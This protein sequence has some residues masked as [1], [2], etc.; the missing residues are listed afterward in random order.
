MGDLFP[1]VIILFISGLVAGTM[2]TIAGGGGLITV[3]VLF[4]FPWSPVVAF[5]TNKFQSTFGSF[6]ATY[7]FW[8]AGT[9]GRGVFLGVLFTAAGA[10]SGAV[11]VNIVPALWL[12]KFIPFL[13]F[14]IALV[15]FFTKG[16]GA[17]PGRQRMPVPLFMAVFGLSIGFYDGFFGPGTGT[18]WAMGF[19][20]LLG[21]DLKEATAST[22]LMNFTSNFVSLLFFLWKGAVNFVPGLA[23][24]LGQFIGGWLGTR[25][26]LRK[27][28]KFI[29]PVLIFMALVLAA[30]LFWDN[31]LK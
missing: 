23:M 17:R 11:V 26:V 21:K 15:L 4:S 9:I 25:L 30:K 28:S 5:G 31:W 20:W 3:P 7:H 2:D 22:K 14:A 19:V 27:G 1:T 16:F 24:A 18:F 6:S 29:R 8:R 12:K 13:L 10:F